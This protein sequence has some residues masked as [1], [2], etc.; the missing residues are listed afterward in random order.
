MLHMFSSHNEELRK[1]QQEGQRA[2]AKAKRD[3][4]LLMLQKLKAIEKERRDWETQDKDRLS[5]ESRSLMERISKEREKRVNK[6]RLA[7]QNS[8]LT[9]MRVNQKES[10]SASPAAGEDRS[11]AIQE[12]S[13]ILP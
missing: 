13:T 7:R 12:Q 11:V 5:A 1:K 6:T 10:K 8:S 9:L 3:R 2:L 4:E